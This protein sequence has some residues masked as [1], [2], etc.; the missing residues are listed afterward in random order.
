MM[1]DVRQSEFAFGQRGSRVDGLETGDLSSC[2]GIVAIDRENGLI[3]MAH[4]DVSWLRPFAVVKAF[5]ELR[6]RASATSNVELYDI[7]GLT[8]TMLVLSALFACAVMSAC[9]GIR[10]GLLC[11]ALVA[12]W[13]GATRPYVRLVLLCLG[14]KQP[15]LLTARDVRGGARRWFRFRV[16][17]RMRA[18][19]GVGDG[20]ELYFPERPRGDPRFQLPAAGGW[21]RLTRAK[22]SE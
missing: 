12:V 2:T 8:P 10:L 1:I 22:D 21:F 14:F 9:L 19:A 5:R 20:P 4:L 6:D 11:A 17:F 18:D 16:N 13:A 15:R 3:F 7:A